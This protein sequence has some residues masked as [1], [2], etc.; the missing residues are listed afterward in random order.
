M[1]NCAT[2]TQRNLGPVRP[3]R[4]DDGDA[5]R[6]FLKPLREIA[7]LEPDA[8]LLTVLVR[9][10]SRY[11]F[12]YRPLP[13][14]SF[15]IPDPP[16]GSWGGF[17]RIGLFV[18]SPDHLSGVAKTLGH[19]QREAHA[20]GVGLRIHGA[21]PAPRADSPMAIFPAVGTFSVSAYNGLQVHV[22]PIREVLKYVKRANF[23]IIHLST[24]GPM[25]LV[26]LLAARLAGLP[27][28][29]T[30]HTHFPSYAAT[31]FR[32]PAM[33]DIGWAL[34]RWFYRQMDRVAAPTPTIR[35]ELIRHGCDPDRLCVVGRGVDTQLFNPA[36]RCEAFR[37][38]HVH[39]QQTALLYVG[40]VSLEKN[41]SVLVDAF[42]RVAARRSDIALLVVGDG[43]YRAQMESELQGLP[44][45]FLGVLGGYELATAYAS[46]DCF[47]FPSETDTLGNVV[48]EAQAAGLPVIV[49][50][51]GGPKDCV[52]DGA[53]GLVIPKITAQK[54]ADVLLDLLAQP[55]RLAEMGTTARLY[56]RRF[57]HKASFEAFR[58]MHEDVLAAKAA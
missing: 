56:S 41:L 29:S 16:V 6:R 37:R 46:C 40:R 8:N 14:S 57:T 34:M 54:L 33:E 42:R 21:S 39:P 32:D 1:T 52:Q 49:S 45:R 28:V 31:L 50:G 38:T 24:P 7:G 44:A 10:F 15:P 13:P 20:A 58:Q 27:V 3:A 43:P 26:G 11:A 19:W 5:W 36:R 23:D 30:F 48:L 9:V 2:D 12:D 35:D 53:T 18:D 25:G 22:P 17:P 4:S 47:V 55:E 51:C